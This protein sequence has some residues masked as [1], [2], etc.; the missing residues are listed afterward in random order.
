M[1][2]NLDDDPLNVLGSV[3]ND[4][5][6]ILDCVE[7]DQMILPSSVLDYHYH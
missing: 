3:K 2:R 6:I 4:Q 5:L 7:V 1:L